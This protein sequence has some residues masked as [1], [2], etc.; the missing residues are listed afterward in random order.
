MELE[1]AGVTL[2]EID[3]RLVQLDQSGEDGRTLLRELTEQLAVL[4]DERAGLTEQRKELWREEA[5]VDSARGHAADELKSA[6]RSLAAV[7]D[8]ACGTHFSPET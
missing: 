6:E 8:K 5:K 3:K 1:R 2:S 4:S 7:M